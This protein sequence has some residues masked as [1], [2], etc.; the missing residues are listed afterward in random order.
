M[1]RKIISDIRLFKSD[2]QNE[3][4]GYLTYSFGVKKLVLVALCIIGATSNLSISL[5]VL[6][7]LSAFYGFFELY[8]W[9]KSK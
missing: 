8:K 6:V 9:S 7:V 4:G 1:K 2:A 5:K 3:Y